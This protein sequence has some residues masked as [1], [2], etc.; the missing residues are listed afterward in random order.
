MRYEYLKHHKTVFLKMTGLHINEFDMLID[1]VVP[2]LIEAEYERLNHANRQRDIGGGRNSTLDERDQVLLTVVWLRVYP[3]HEVLGYLFGISDST[4]SRMVA[5]VLPI[6]EQAGRDTMRMPDPGRK[7]RK[8]LDQLLSDTPD[9]A[10]VIDS[11]EQKVQRPKDPNERDGFYSGKKKT[12]T[13]KSQVAVNEETGAIVDISDSVAGPTADINLL[14]Q[15]GLM[16]R[17]PDGVGG[18]GDLAYVG[19]ENLHPQGKGACPRR[20]PR[21]KPRPPEDVAYNTLFSR[22]RII[23]ENTIARFRRYQSLTQ[24]DRQHRQNHASRVRAVAGLVNRQLACR[25]PA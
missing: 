16:K 3:T 20:K 7:R 9:L 18:I 6:L 24:T 2:Q 4:V 13:L 17:L 22:R 19:I 23:V 15:S 8:S 21:G 12:H 11:F 14:E 1:D 10:V 5:R 25:M